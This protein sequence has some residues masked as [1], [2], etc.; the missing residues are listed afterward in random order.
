MAELKTKETKASVSAFLKT[1]PADRRKDAEGIVQIMKSATKER[2]VMWGTSIV[3]FGRLH[4]KYASGRE[5]DWFK[6][7]FSPRKDSFTL[8]L[9]GGFEPH[10]DLMAKLGKHKTGG[11]CV[12]IKKLEDVDAKV[13]KQLVARTTK[14]AKNFVQSGFDA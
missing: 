4:M 7:G 14:A 2:P 1:L 3:G 6:A 13:L 10:A 11:G 9:C 5:L 12:Y 8:Y